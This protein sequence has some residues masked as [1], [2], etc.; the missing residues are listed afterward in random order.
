[1]NN[2]RISAARLQLLRDQLPVTI[3]GV[4]IVASGFALIFWPAVDH[5]LLLGWLGLQY[6]LSLSRWLAIRRFDHLTPGLPQT[7]H[8]LRLLTFA[9]GISG[10]LWG[11]AA[12][13]FMLPTEPFYVTTLTMILLAMATGS[14]PGLSVHPPA[15]AAFVV[16]TVS[17]LA[18]K[19]S[20]IG[21]QGYVLSILILLFLLVNLFFARNMHHALIKSLHLRFA[22]LALVDQLQKQKEI[23]EEANRA[24]SR[25]LAAASHDLRQPLHAL[26]LFVDTLATTEEP[27]T[28]AALLDRINS[29]VTAL[30]ELFNALLDISR[31]DAGVV[32]VQCE[33]FPLHG[34]LGKLADEYQAVAAEKGLRLHLHPCGAIAHSDPLLLE[35]ILRNLIS[36]AIRYTERGRILLG[37]RQRGAH[38]LVQVWDTGCGIPA[39]AQG[40]IFKEFQQLHNPERDRHKGLGLGLAIVRRLCELLEHRIT[41]R[42]QAGRGSCFTL[43]IARG[44]RTQP[45]AL[46]E[47]DLHP[48]ANLQGRVIL[49]IDDEDA[50]RAAMSE[51]LDRWGCV[52]VT[53][54]SLAKAQQHLAK[55]QLR[56]ELILADLRLRAGQTGIHAIEVL[57]Q[58]CGK[59]IPAVIIT[60]DSA[61]ERLRAAHTAGYHLLHKPVKAAQLRTLINRLLAS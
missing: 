48:D 17:S 35:R 56:P 8:W 58:D 29:S 18:W 5:R 33:D 45:F 37:C 12:W 32:R 20:Q 30:N 24:K 34:V 40:D 39:A 59:N 27:R 21:S 55:R 3:S 25:F 23:A 10:C 16:P 15:Y 61:P 22:N 38:I 36:N 47:P 43:R 11:S 51:Y 44:Y 13:I 41:V 26:G 1:M 14:M 9:S 53:A 6:T 28:R 60:G 49:I 4:V 31:L 50:I 19:V 57:R 46:P 2:E 7:S 52:V 54:E 42:S